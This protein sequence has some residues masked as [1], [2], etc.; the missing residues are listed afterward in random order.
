MLRY[1]MIF[2][3]CKSEISRGVKI[4]GQ[5]TNILLFYKKQ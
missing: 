3:G 4:I 5:R 2:C 1:P